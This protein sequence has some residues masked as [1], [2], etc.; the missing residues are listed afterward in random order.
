MRFLPGL[1]FLFPTLVLAAE[2]QPGTGG[3]S[4]FA[5]FIQMLF[6]LMVVLGLMMATYYGVNRLMKTMPGLRQTGRY[7][8]VVEVK[9]MG[10]RKALI[11][12]EI[13]GEYLLLSSCDNSISFLKQIDML[14]EIEVLD[15]P[16]GK[17]TFLSFLQRLQSAG[18]S[19]QGG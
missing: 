15:E 18:Q 8:R 5:S 12:V 9:P 1:L 19:G 4:L 2:V 16:S 11:L 17:K 7:I 13:S 14:E 10:P 3:Y 6:A